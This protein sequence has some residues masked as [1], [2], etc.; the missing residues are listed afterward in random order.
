MYEDVILID[1]V[2]ISGKHKYSEEI[3]EACVESFCALPLAAI[4]N[5]QFFCV[6]GGLSPGLTT[7]DD[8]KVVKFNFY[9][10]CC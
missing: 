3:Y 9:F 6:H 10:N 8:L 2:I 1:H 7:L 5:K 4:M